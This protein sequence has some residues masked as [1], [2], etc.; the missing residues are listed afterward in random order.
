[1]R[2]AR[3]RPGAARARRP[4]RWRRSGRGGRRRPSVSLPSRGPP[5]PR[6]PRSA[7]MAETPAPPGPSPR[8]APPARP[9]TPAGSSR[10]PRTGRV[11]QGATNRAG[12][13]R[14]AAPRQPDPEPLPPALQAPLDRPPRPAE[15]LGRLLVR[16][17]LQVAEHQRGAVLLGQA[18]QLLV[19]QLL[20]LAQG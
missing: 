9:L 4:R 17:P 19:Q 20:K 14:R 5:P 2:A 13:A 10:L 11:R 7:G 18:G 6:C 8:P 15:L 16:A 1:S 3:P 12:G